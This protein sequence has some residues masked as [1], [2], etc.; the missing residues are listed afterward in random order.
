MP[1]PGSQSPGAMLLFAPTAT[2]EFGS[3]VAAA[4]G[5][6]LSKHEELEFGAGEHTVR[7]LES[8]RRRSVYVI[9]SLHGDALGSA[10][11]KLCRLLFFIGALKDAGARQVTACL[12]Y[13]AYSRTDRRTKP[14]GPVTTRYVAQVIEAVGAD[15]VVT[16]DV[17]NL[18][19]FENSFRCETVNL[20]AAGYF[21]QRFLAD[22]RVDE[23]VVVSPDIGGIKRAHHF[24]ECLELSL[25]H[26]V[27]VGYMDKRRRDGIVSGD[28]FLGNV[29]CQQVILIDDLISSG[30]TILRATDACRRAGATRVDVAVTHATFSSEAHRLFRVG[31][32]ESV[33][34]T[35]SVNLGSEFFPYL[36][37][38]LHVLGVATLFAEAIRC[39]EQSD[40]DP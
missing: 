18:A 26:S 21:V 7:P 29:K 30:T 12:P 35:D 10:N 32:P 34:I 2:A 38:S 37:Q 16:L 8:V 15:K 33:L 36:N 9:Q 31:G 39:L 14:R 28:T 20:E 19:A 23:S 3:R 22:A 25:G 5:V 17:H 27:N 13:L 6:Q 4:L 1:Q 40:T 11:D 24:Q